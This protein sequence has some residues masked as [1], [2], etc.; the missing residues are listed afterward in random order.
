[1]CSFYASIKSNEFSLILVQDFIKF[2]FASLFAEQ[3]CGGMNAICDEEAYPRAVVFKLVPG[4]PQL[5]TFC[6]SP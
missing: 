2:A 3:S 1:M 4:D 6:T 5:C